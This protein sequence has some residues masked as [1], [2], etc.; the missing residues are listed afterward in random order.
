MNGL[1]FDFRQ[2]FRTLPPRSVSLISGLVL[3]IAFAVLF[4]NPFTQRNI[5]F[6]TRIEPMMFPGPPADTTLLALVYFAVAGLALGGLRLLVWDRVRG[7]ISLPIL[8]AVMLT[9]SAALIYGG[10]RLFNPALACMIESCNSTFAFHYALITLDAGVVLA[11]N[12]IPNMATPVDPKTGEPYTK[13][14]CSMNGGW[15]LIL[16]VALVFGGF[17]M[18]YVLNNVLGHG[19]C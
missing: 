12:G 5:A 7:L 10:L 13:L 6:S 1:T 18:L 9:G 4:F 11:F 8:L 17:V 16:G 2:P 14:G 15:L 19:E 3:G